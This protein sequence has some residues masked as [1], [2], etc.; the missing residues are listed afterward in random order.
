MKSTPAWRAKSR[1]VSNA[2]RYSAC[3][4][5]AGTWS[6]RSRSRS[7]HSHQPPPVASAS[8]TPATGPSV[9]DRAASVGRPISLNCPGCGKHYEV[10]AVLAGKK[11]RCKQCKE[12]FTIPVPMGIVTAL[13]PKPGRATSPPPPSEPPFV[14]MKLIFDD[15]PVAF[16]RA[17]S[18]EE[19]L[20]APRRIAASKPSRKP[21][22]RRSMD[23]QLGITVSGWFLALNALAFLGIWIVRSVVDPTLRTF[24]VGIG[25]YV[26]LLGISSL[27]LAAWGGIWL[28]VVAF[29]ESTKQGLLCLLVPCYQL[30]YVLSRWQDTRGAICL[31]FS[32]QIPVIRFR[33]RES[34]DD[35]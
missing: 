4:Y 7:R 19:E 12:V 21:S 27:V 17:Q 11:S 8:R 13:A 14:E 3:P 32:S 22:D 33:R 23:P 28:L 25:L 10:D 15:E 29:Q 1:A 2:A 31:S 30:Y 16:K 9:A 35:T 26:I 5:R 34:A 6:R 24:L 20:P 18:D